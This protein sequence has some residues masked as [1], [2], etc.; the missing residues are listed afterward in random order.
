MNARTALELDYIKF[1]NP[2][3]IPGLESCYEIFFHD[4][5]QIGKP[6][7]NCDKHVNPF[8]K[9]LIEMCCEYN[10]LI[11]NGRSPSDPSGN[12]TYLSAGGSSTIDYIL[13]SNSLFCKVNDFCVLNNDISK[14]FPISCDI[15]LR[16]M[17]DKRAV[18][19]TT[20]RYRW[21]EKNSDMFESLISEPEFMDDLEDVYRVLDLNNIDKAVL[22]LNESLK[23]VGDKANMRCGPKRSRHPLCPWFD[24]DLEVLKQ[25]KCKLLN[26]FRLTNNEADLD[27]Y[28]NVKNRFKLDCKSKKKSYQK[29]QLEKLCDDKDPKMFWIKIKVYIQKRI[30]PTININIEN[31]YNHFKSLLNPLVESSDEEFDDYVNDYIR[32]NKCKHNEC[33]SDPEY[34]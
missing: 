31:W 12:Y 17:E 1:D 21:K 10:L 22:K 9:C 15:K 27:D 4:S 16:S 26:K 3:Y 13:V 34:Y 11:L 32:D 2:S 23:T 18:C 30:P 25:S 29:S 19:D 24:S 5:V 6:R 33:Q 14:H 28:L 20:V 7:Q 8:G